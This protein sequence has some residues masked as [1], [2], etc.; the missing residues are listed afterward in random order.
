VQTLKAIQLAAANTKGHWRGCSAVKATEVTLD[1]P[2]GRASIG[3]SGHRMSGPRIVIA[4]L[5]L[6]LDWHSFLNRPS[7]QKRG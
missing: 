6:H 7:S 4:R 2:Y 3:G 5:G 1:G